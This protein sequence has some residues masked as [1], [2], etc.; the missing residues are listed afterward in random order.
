[1]SLRSSIQ[2]P[3]EH[4]DDTCT[5]S[6]STGSIPTSLPPQNPDLPEHVGWAYGA[7]LLTH[8]TKWNPDGRELTIFYPMSLSSPDHVQLMRSRFV[9]P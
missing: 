7:F 4:T 1:M 6:E 2:T 8:Y 9:V 3:R 5:R